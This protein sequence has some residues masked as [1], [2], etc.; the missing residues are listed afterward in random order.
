M[1]KIA[2]PVTNNKLSTHFGHCEKFYFYEINDG[3]IIKETQL[4]PPPH[5]PGLLPK[6]LYRHLVTDVIAGGLGNRAIN[7]FNHFGINVFVGAPVK[8]PA[9]LVESHLNGNLKLSENYCGH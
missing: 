6:W 5:E 4:I 7:Q 8:H 9:E 2:I 3:E 1:K